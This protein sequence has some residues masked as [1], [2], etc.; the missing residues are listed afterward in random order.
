MGGFFPPLLGTIMAKF[1]GFE[2]TR[3]KKQLKTFAPPE[4]DDGAL[5]VAAGGAFGQYIDMDGSIKNEVELINK[6]REMSIHPECDMAIDAIVNE[7]IVVSEEKENAVNLD[8]NELGAPDN[9]KKKIHE[10]W[11]KIVQALDFNKKGYE[12]FRKWYID[13]RLYYHIIIDEERKKRGIQ[14]L[15]YVDPRKIRKVREVQKVRSEKANSAELVKKVEEFFVYNEKATRPDSTVQEGIKVMP[16]AVAHVTRG[17]F[18]YKKM[19]TL[20][21]LHKAVKPL[22]QLTMMEDALVIYRISRAPERR[23]FY[24]D[25]GNL[26][27]AKAEQYLRETMSQYR[28]KLVYNAETG[29]IKDERKHMSMLEDFWLPRREGGR[30][31]EI[32]TLQGGQNLGEMEDVLYFQVKL[33]KALNVP[34]SRL[35]E[36]SSGFSLGRES[37]ISRD[38]MKFSKFIDRLRNKFTEFFDQLLKAQLILMGIIKEEDWEKIQHEIQYEWAE[39]SYYREQKTAEI[40]QM[41]M[42]LLS[43]V[44]EYAG[45]YFSMEYIKKNILQMTDK[46][47]RQMQ[48]QIDAEVNDEK[49]APEATIEWGAMGA[50]GGEPKEG[51]GEPPPEGEPPQ[52]EMQPSNGNGNGQQPPRAEENQLLTNEKQFDINKIQRLLNQGA[53]NGS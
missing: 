29:E 33:Y 47:I 25:V 49:L 45:R 13:G 2:V 27:K 1:F 26:P 37:E 32:T 52:P 12:I 17:Q 7:A 14:E 18:D 28:N 24:I 23:I 36:Q 22:N 20:G 42:E 38:E 48:K 3:A 8:L 50:T 43:T 19:N 10:A 15:R 30:G 39:D 41:R 53:D 9:V 40:L 35:D 44:A 34:S 4:N 5:G 11:D 16:D 51:E 46:E 21:Y 31:T 6:Y